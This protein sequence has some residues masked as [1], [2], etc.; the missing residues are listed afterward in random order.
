MHV[1]NAAARPV[2]ASEI[3]TH[4]TNPHFGVRGLHIHVRVVTVTSV[5]A[6]ST[7]LQ[8]RHSRNT[9]NLH[10]CSDHTIERSTSSGR[11]L[12]AGGRPARVNNSETLLQHNPV[13]KVGLPS[14]LRCACPQIR[15]SDW[16][17]TT[18]EVI[19]AKP[20]STLFPC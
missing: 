6:Q 12:K 9:R 3:S 4:P 13:S 11:E 7:C 14:P 20:C 15:K 18:H 1:T 16:G 5:S 8:C 10:R 19:A 2:S 17:L